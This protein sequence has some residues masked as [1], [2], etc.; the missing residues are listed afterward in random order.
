VELTTLGCIQGH[1]GAIQID[2]KT[3]FGEESI[4]Y[5]LPAGPHFLKTRLYPQ[6][7]ISLPSASDCAFFPAEVAIAPLVSLTNNPAVGQV[8]RPRVR[9]S[10][11]PYR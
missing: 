10:I 11:G 3:S 4:A 7:Q 9:L 8:T 2:A 1:P 6:R 5:R